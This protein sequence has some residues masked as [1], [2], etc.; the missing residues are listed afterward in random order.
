MQV[1]TFTVLWLLTAIYLIFSYAAQLFSERYIPAR[2]KFVALLATT[3]LTTVASLA[4]DM[5]VP[6]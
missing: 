2:D 4:V 6:S 3:A 1:R 5:E